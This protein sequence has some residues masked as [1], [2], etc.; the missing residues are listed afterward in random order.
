M[1]KAFQK[2]FDNLNIEYIDLYLIH[3]PVA[4]QRVLKSPGLSLD[5]FDSF[6]TFPVDENGKIVYLRRNT[7]EI[8]SKNHL[9]GKPL[10]EDVDYL[11]TWREME[12]LVEGGKV[13]SI[14]ISNFNSEQTARLLSIAKIKPVTNQ[15]E[16]HPNLNQ[17]KLI[18]FSAAKN[19]TITA[20]S[21]LGRVDPKLAISS[22]KIL[23]MAQKYG[24]TPAQIVLRYSVYLLSEVYWME[25]N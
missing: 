17:R 9:L 21:P 7:I 25:K 1:A 20:Y 6:K 15:V 4:Y 10:T 5:D 8:Q 19:I 16:C 14:G 2:S 24:K 3:N 23:E 12:K 11:D 22:P 13:R 18:E